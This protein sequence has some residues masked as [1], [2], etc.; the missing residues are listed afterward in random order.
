[1]ALP[2]FRVRA[3]GVVLIAVLLAVF[4]LTATPSA[5]RAAAG[6][7][8]RATAAKKAHKRHKRCKASKRRRARRHCP[9]HHRRRAHRPKKHKISRK[10]RPRKRAPKHLEVARTPLPSLGRLFDGGF[11]T[12]DFSQ[13]HVQRA[14]PDRIR[15]VRSPVA[16]GSWAA[17]FEVR[18]G[19][20]VA[21]GDSTGNRAEVYARGSQ[22]R[23]P[24]P[25]GSERYYGWSTFIPAD[26]PLD[27]LWQI[28]V[29][30]KGKGS[31][32][33]PLAIGFQRDL[34]NVTAMR[35]DGSGTTKVWRGRYKPGQWDRLVMHVRWSPNPAIGFIE[36]W[37][38]GELVLPRM[39][40]ATMRKEADGTGVPN[41]FKMGLY[42]SAGIESTQALYQDDARIGLSYQDVAR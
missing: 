11:E 6:P 12:G 24:D 7:G 35:P 13:W 23:W 39:P 17:R 27:P 41:Y 1:M 9:R 21:P 34:L 32:S 40:V 30:W 26:Y 38:D 18:K 14:A 20:V 5:S 10:A 19:D 2:R 16:A 8:Q 33:P 25:E 15:L 22:D 3:L 36:L 37:R 42:R 29:Q 4:A 28:I 31:G